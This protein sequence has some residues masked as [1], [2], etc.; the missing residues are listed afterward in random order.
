MTI[1]FAVVG[2]DHPHLFT[3]AHGLVEAGRPAGRPRAVR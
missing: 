2:A 3:L 1:G